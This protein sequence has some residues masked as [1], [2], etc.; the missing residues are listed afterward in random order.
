MAKLLSIRNNT[1]APLAATLALA[2][3][4]GAAASKGFAVWVRAG[5]PAV[6]QLATM[7]QAQA[8]ELMRAWRS[9]ALPLFLAVGAALTCLGLLAWLRRRWPDS[10]QLPLDT[11]PLVRSTR[12]TVLWWAVAGA[13][14]AAT[15]AG[16]HAA[17]AALHPVGD[18]ASYLAKAAEF[19]RALLHADLGALAEVWQGA[20]HRP[21]PGLSGIYLGTLLGLP[22][23]G[24][25]ALQAGLAGALAGAG[26]GWA[27]RAQHWPYLAGLA[28]LALLL[29]Q[30]LWRLTTVI[31]L[32]DAVLLG[33]AV[34]ALGLALQ[35]RQSPTS[36]ATWALAAALALAPACKPSGAV[37][38]TVPILAGLALE[39]LARA[40]SELPRAAAA[41]L[42]LALRSSLLVPTALLIGGGPKVFGFVA[43]HGLIVESL[44]LY[45]ESVSGPWQAL[46]WL[47]LAPTHFATPPLLALAIA[48]AWKGRHSPIR[49]AGLAVVLPL[50]VHAF[51]MSSKSMRLLES[52]LAGLALLSGHAVSELHARRPRHASW[53]AFAVLG[54]LFMGLAIDIKDDSDTLALVDLAQPTGQGS[55]RSPP[56]RIWGALPTSRGAEAWPRAGRAVLAATAQHCDRER[57]SMLFAEPRL[58]PGVGSS[59][60]GL[61]IGAR[62]FYVLDAQANPAWP[63]L[64]GSRGCLVTHSQQPLYWPDGRG[65]VDG[66]GLIKALHRA[67]ERKTAA[68]QALTAGFT[69]VAS[70][71]LPDGA[72]ATVHKRASDADLTERLLWASWL[73]EQVPGSGSA[74][75]LWAGIGNEL[76][77]ANRST[78]ACKVWGYAAAARPFRGLVAWEK[79]SAS[80]F[81]QEQAA[82]SA[83]AQRSRHACPAISPAI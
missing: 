52:G 64:L 26:I 3:V 50:L 21:W 16:L 37:W 71:V 1:L 48:G 45:D 65:R 15:Y 78:E 36:R 60:Y 32:A 7:D 41:F 31:P 11:S 29:G 79:I 80:F 53:L 35:W 68:D 56:L 61:G 69:A 75:A 44:G 20:G 22:Y 59:D 17:A 10:T 47:A 46:H 81:A 58:N 72:T 49:L 34:L 18:A 38:V 63:T 24:V 39:A 33:S 28:A 5:R 40:R 6:D 4:A 13:A 25:V 27:A 83:R 14:V 19:R 82:R 62:S 2:A 42:T 77:A 51:L 23:A 57:T 70:F 73:A 9:L 76:Q 54:G 30:P 8:I 55:W 74:A 12:A 66:E 43:H 67:L